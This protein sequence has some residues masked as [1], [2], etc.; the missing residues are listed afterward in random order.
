MSLDAF[1]S[2]PLCVVQ[3]YKVITMKN[4]RFDYIIVI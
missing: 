1:S 4:N 3:I 2:K